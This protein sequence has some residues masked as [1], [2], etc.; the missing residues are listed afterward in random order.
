M[1][2][3]VG[4]MS[5]EKFLYVLGGLAFLTFLALVSRITYA[6]FAPNTDD[7]KTSNVLVK[8]STVDEFSFEIG[9]PL[10]LTATPETL[11]E[12]GENLVFEST[13]SALLKANSGSNTATYDYYIYLKLSDNTF[14][15]TNED[16]PEII[17]TVTNKEGNPVTDI[18][19][20]TY[21]TF[22]GVDGF[23]VTTANG[24]F[25]VASPQITSNSSTEVTTDDWTFTLT[26]LN[27]GFDQSVN[28]GH[29]MKTE[30]S[31]SK[32]LK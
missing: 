16:T 18:S 22:N 14:V 21:G 27:L 31:M 25:L 17:L 4:W 19:G 9:E 7:E 23:D 12:G 20:L 28:F 8:Q 32:T 10:T 13:S 2:K 3:S 5:R 26:Y 6:Y 15:Y 1:D 30:L 24:E 11:P 29:S